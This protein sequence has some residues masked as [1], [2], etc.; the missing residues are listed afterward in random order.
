LTPEQFRILRQK[1]TGPAR[2]RHPDWISL[3]PPCN[4]ACPAGDR[5]A[6]L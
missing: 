1:G 4:A 6:N 3:L 2:T 5:A